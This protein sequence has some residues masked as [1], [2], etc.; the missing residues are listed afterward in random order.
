MKNYLVLVVFVAILAAACMTMKGFAVYEPGRWTGM[1]YGYGGRIT[2][3][4]VTDTNSILDISVLEQ[5][6]DL[7]IGSNAIFFLKTSILE[8]NSTDVDV[9]AHA[10]ATSEGFI[11]A[12]RNALSNARIKR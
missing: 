6:E 8:T 3:L 1:A 10:T 11:N 12:V 5:Y 9:V 2:V 4:V 7:E